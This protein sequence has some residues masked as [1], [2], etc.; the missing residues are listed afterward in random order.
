VN[1]AQNLGVINGF[2]SMVSMAPEGA[3][4]V[5]GGNWRLFSHMAHSGATSIHLNTT[6]DSIHRN[7]TSGSFTLHSSS[8]LKSS[9]FSD[10]DEVIV[11]GPHQFTKIS[12]KPSLDN[13]PDEVPYVSLHVTL[14][15]SPHF[16]SP[17]AFKLEPGA[18]V[19]LVV[20]TS[21]S[22]DEEPGQ[23]TPYP[24][25][26]GFFSISLLRPVINP[27]TKKEEYLY[28]IFSPKVVTPHFLANVLG[29]T[30]TPKTVDGFPKDDVSWIYQKIWNSY[31]VEYPRVTFEP[32][33]LA[34]HVWYTGGMDSF[35]SCM[36]TNA[37]MGMN[38]ARLMV[39]EWI[40]KDR[41]Q[42]VCVDYAKPHGQKVLGVT[43]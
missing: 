11:A 40:K 13:V 36:E 9:N 22:E 2:V 19:P 33:K 31:P 16:L 21:L 17:A 4:R 3:V 5:D 32:I 18:Q 39:D 23:Q 6:I 24:G 15:T 7:S 8:T 25:K 42:H 37:L 30:D 1:Y 34:P 41:K 38:V 27:K 35:A 29:L 12:F 28:K 10:F 20:L 26:A 43:K 14:F